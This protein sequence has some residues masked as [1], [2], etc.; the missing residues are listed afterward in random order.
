V[1]AGIKLKT[2]LNMK[3]VTNN[4]NLRISIY[5]NSIDMGISCGQLCRNKNGIRQ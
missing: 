3:K 1:L 5:D 4:N 2:S